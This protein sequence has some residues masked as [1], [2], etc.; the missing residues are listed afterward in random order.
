MDDELFKM[1]DRIEN[2]LDTLVDNSSHARS[3]INWVDKIAKFFM[4]GLSRM[5]GLTNINKGSRGNL[6]GHDEADRST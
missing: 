3:H 6:R 1:L 5:L 4:P 2:K